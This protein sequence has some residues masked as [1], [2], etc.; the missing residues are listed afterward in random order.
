MSNRKLIN[1]YKRLDVL[2][3][4][5]LIKDTLIPFL[6]VYDGEY[7]TTLTPKTRFTIQKHYYNDQFMGWNI[8]ADGKLLE[9]KSSKK[10]AIK[11]LFSIVS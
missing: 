9:T 5:G 2:E 11:Y 10:K 6:D 8:Y 4:K 1:G 3:Y 7:I